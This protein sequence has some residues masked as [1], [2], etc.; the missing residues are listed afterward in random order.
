M[1]GGLSKAKWGAAG[2][3]MRPGWAQL[4]I[5]EAKWGSAAVSWAQSALY[6]HLLLLGFH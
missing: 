4:V 2:G 1:S 5:N 3:T 6:A